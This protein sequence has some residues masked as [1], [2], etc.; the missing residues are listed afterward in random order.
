MVLVCDSCL[1][2][3][4]YGTMPICSK[5]SVDAGKTYRHWPHCKCGVIMYGSSAIDDKCRATEPCKYCKAGV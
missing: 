2:S 4:N 1:R 5:C 3:F